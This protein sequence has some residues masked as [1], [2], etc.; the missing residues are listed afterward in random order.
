MPR[1]KTYDKARVLIVDDHPALREALATRI[2]RQD[3]MAVCGEAGSLHDALVMIESLRPDLAV[4]DISLKSDSGIELIKE[5]KERHEDVRILVWSMH[6]DFDYADR[7]LRAGA[8][9]YINKDQ[10]TD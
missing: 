5:V 7:S 6:T 3:D 1:L 2:C 4:V 9:G 8:L 10:A